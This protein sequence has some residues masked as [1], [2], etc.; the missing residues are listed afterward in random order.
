MRPDGENL[1][2]VLLVDDQ[3]LIRAGV[4]MVLRSVPDILVV[5]EASD[6]AL[7]LAALRET[8][9]DVVLMD[10]RMH[11]MD[12]IEATA[13]MRTDFPG[14]CVVLLT[15][16]D[17]DGLVRAGLAAG[18]DGFVLK[19]APPEELLRA[20]HTVADGGAYV[21]PMLAKRLL[22]EYRPQLYEAPVAAGSLDELTRRE[23]EVFTLVARGLTNSQIAERLSL[24]PVTVRTHVDN[25][26]G[27][28]RL[29]HR[30]RLIVFAYENDLVRPQR[31]DEP[32]A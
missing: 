5:G 16:F 31:F 1:L 32:P 18:A 7:A 30:S 8:P 29:P 20:I 4:R 10:V 15:A 26:L 24:S 14:T 2:R 3:E 22:D 19:D 9:A 12:G 21:S 17:E 11:G 27:K 13:R 25:V 28:L 23:Q 6:G